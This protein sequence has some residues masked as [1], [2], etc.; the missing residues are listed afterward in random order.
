MSVRLY[1]NE[2]PEGLERLAGV[3][4]GTY[5]KLEAFEAKHKQPKPDT[6]IAMDEK[7]ADLYRR[8]MNAWHDRMDKDM[9]KLYGFKSYGWGRLTGDA[10]HYIEEH[11]ESYEAGSTDDF[12]HA[13]AL[14]QAMGIT[15]EGITSVR[16]N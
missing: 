11:F 6:A 5:A 10:W 9:A 8:A 14:V 13:Q 7:Y 15:A 12:R 1:P 2:T 4:T 3:P 16:W